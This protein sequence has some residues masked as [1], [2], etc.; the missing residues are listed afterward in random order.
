M[1]HICLNVTHNT[2]PL[3]DKISVYC[4]LIWL[5]QHWK[6]GENSLP[7]SVADVRVGELGSGECR[8]RTAALPTLL[9]DTPTITSR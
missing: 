3:T 9:S 2:E 6:A 5:L 7:G 4:L 1:L 8:L